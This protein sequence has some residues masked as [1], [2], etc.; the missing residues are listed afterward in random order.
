MVKLLL[1]DKGKQLFTTYNPVEYP[2]CWSLL[3]LVHLYPLDLHVTWSRSFVQSGRWEFW[4]FGLCLFSGWHWV[5]VTTTRPQFT[6]TGNLL[7]VKRKG[8]CH[9]FHSRT[10]QPRVPQPT[11]TL[12]LLSALSRPLGFAHRYNHHA[13]R[14]QSRTACPTLERRWTGSSAMAARSRLGCRTL[15]RRWTG[16]SVAGRSRNGC[17]TL[18]R[19]WTGA[20]AARRRSTYRSLTSLDSP[21]WAPHDPPLI[22]WDTVRLPAQ[23]QMSRPT[24]PALPL[25]LFCY[26]A[27]DMS[28]R[29]IPQATGGGG[30]QLL[31]PK[32]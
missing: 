28:L 21:E 12:F 30:G 6:A 14:G 19:R 8:S 4:H 29:Q 27:S 7:S 31:W 1:L 16:P 18:Q 22:S 26:L 2:A 13:R 5:L 23:S 32:D 15:Q 24:P 25:S 11:P 10:P 17:H 20:A 9:R 3:R